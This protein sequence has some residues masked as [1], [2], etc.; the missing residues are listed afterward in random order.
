MLLNPEGPTAPPTGQ[1][2]SLQSRRRWDSLQGQ[3]SRLAVWCSVNNLILNHTK[4]KD[5]II[6]FCKNSAAP[7]PLLINGDGVERVSDSRVLGTLIP[8]D[9]SW[10]V[11]WWKVKWWQGQEQK[12]RCILFQQTELGELE[13][14][15]ITLDVY[16]NEE[17]YI[18][19]FVY[20]YIA[21][22]NLEEHLWYY[23]ITDV[24]IITA[25]QCII[26]IAELSVC[27]LTN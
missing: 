10:K 26:N 16:N 9:L 11:K 22:L 20:L 8:E 7:Q 14:E 5:I 12:E 4:T 27:L 24:L 15:D 6:D 17:P 25:M 19:I 1:V 23:I 13:K 21:S 2:V 3:K 18:Y